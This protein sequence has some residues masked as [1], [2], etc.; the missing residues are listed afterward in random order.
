M[1][2][3]ITLAVLSLCGSAEAAWERVGNVSSS[4]S[5]TSYDRKDAF[6]TDHVQNYGYVDRIKFC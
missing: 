6:F 2:F 4:I 1:N 5:G 3:R